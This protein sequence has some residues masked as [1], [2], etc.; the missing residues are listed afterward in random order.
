[1][2]I[3]SV[4]AG[5][6]TA[7]VAVSFVNW[8]GST[9][10]YS[11]GS[12]AVFPL[13]TI[14]GE[15][16]N[17]PGEIDLVVEAGGSG[18]GVTKIVTSKTQ[19]G[20]LSRSPKVSEAGLPA[21]TTGAPTQKDYQFQKQWIDNKLKTITLGWD[22]I[23]VVYK[24]YAGDTTVLDINEKNYETLFKAFAGNTQVSYSELDEKPTVSTQYLKPYAR[25]GGSKKSGTADAFYN[26]SGFDV[27]KLPEKTIDAL[28]YGSYG[29]ITKQTKEN[30]SE[31]WAYI[32]EGTDLE[33]RI[34]YLS[35]GFVLNNLDLIKSKGFK[36]A[37]YKKT[38]LASDKIN[39]GYDWVR[40]LNTVISLN[41]KDD[42]N[43]RSVKTFIEWVMSG[44][45]TNKNQYDKHLDKLFKEVGIKQ[46]SETEYKTMMINNN[47]W[48]DDYQLIKSD[49]KNR[50]DDKSY[51]GAYKTTKENKPVW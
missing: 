11:S 31:V 26:Y 16:Y 27:K 30:N 10:I 19:M 45:D 23:C 48:V 29:E 37:T 41:S 47:F 51:Y 38:E 50:K 44:P 28:K 9:I 49:T 8:N 32:S 2:V 20:N 17:G 40:P 25:N 3:T 42:K 5:V 15:Q 21:G 13:M 24:P 46:L 18:T 33:G 43:S 4:I 39:N 34:T 35:T 7:A 22:G 1:M 14:L 12:S 6:A 36:I